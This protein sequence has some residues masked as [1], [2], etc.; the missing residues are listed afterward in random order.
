MTRRRLI[1][2]MWLGVFAGGVATI[3]IA[4]QPLPTTRTDFYTPGSQPGSLV[5]PLISTEQ[6]AFCHADYAEEQAPYNRW[7]ASMMGQAAR[8]PIFHAALAIA[9]QDAANAGESC[10]R[11]HSPGGFM[12]GHSVPPDGSALTGTDFE[13]VSC[14]V[15][16]RMVNPQYAPGVSP[17]VDESILAGV[18][19]PPLAD[20]H[21]GSFVFDP[22][23]RRRGPFDLQADWASTE[24]GGWPGFHQFLQSPFHESSQMC[25]TCHDVSIPTF[26]RQANGEYELNT[27]DEPGPSKYQQYPEQRTYSEWANSLFAQAPVDLAGRFGG[28]RGAVSSCQDCHMPGVNGTGC[29]L[30]G[31]MRPKL[32]QHNLNGANSWVL[33]A[34][35][36]AYFDS[37][38]GLTG[39]AVDDAIARN[40]QMMQAASDLQLTR[41]GSELNV[42]IINFTGHKLPTGY[43]EGRRMWIN[44]R[45]L[46]SGGQVVAEHGAYDDAEATLDAGS[47]KVYEMESAISPEVAALSGQ[48]PGQSFHLVLNSDIIKDNR[49]PPMGYTRAAF[50]AV[51]A[52]HTPGNLYNDGQYWDDTR[53]EIPAGASRVEVRVMHQTTTR[54]YIEF[55]RDENETNNKGMIAYDLWDLVGGRSAPI[56]MDSQS[57]V[58]GCACDWNSTGGLTLQDLF[59]FLTDW[60]NSDGDFNGAGGTTLQDIFDYLTCYFTGCSG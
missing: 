5:D 10:I 38:T 32:P 57:L 14:S 45:F 24:F 54:E 11:C 43:P 31:P 53:F 50:E 18:S 40:V 52:G 60:F 4:S 58:L 22:R 51:G 16:H 47:T 41:I 6:C 7:A 8:D 36:S 37:E 56:E 17:A 49:I 9:N 55:L 34:V 39:Q 21:N 48:Q 13:G 46:D 2:G 42:R 27:V 15:C 59:D 30:D 44:V 20:P 1:E 23:D 12:A 26:T 25:G 33:R 29:A 3:A 28:T 19:P 35:R